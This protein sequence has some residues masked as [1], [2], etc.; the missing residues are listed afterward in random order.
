MY[1][2]RT[3]AG[4]QLNSHATSESHRTKG[5]AELTWHFA[6]FVRRY[7]L[8]YDM[9][10]GLAK[11]S[12]LP[13]KNGRS[14]NLSK[15]FLCTRTQ[16][17]GLSWAHS[18]KIADHH[19]NTQEQLFFSLSLSTGVEFS[20]C[21]VQEKGMKVALRSLCVLLLPLCGV[22]AASDGGIVAKETVT[23][24]RQLVRITE[25]GDNGNP[26]PEAFP[27]PLCSGDCDNDDEVRTWLYVT[28][29]RC[30]ASRLHSVE[31]FLYIPYVPTY[32]LVVRRGI[33]LLS[34]SG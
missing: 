31:P 22:A 9:P 21:S 17:D 15:I 18:Q 26:P 32:R 8:H 10:V 5:T 12:H 23:K 24:L 1:S 20:Y 2:S 4:N 27:L 28:F 25:L 19:K 14:R 6:A 34:K 33:D 7:W 3:Q 30:A 13:P 29:D 16:A 11:N